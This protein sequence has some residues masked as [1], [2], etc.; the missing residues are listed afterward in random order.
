MEN[1]AMQDRVFISYIA[2]QKQYVD[3]IR[4]RLYLLLDDPT[5]IDKNFC[6]YIQKMLS[7]T[8]EAFRKKEASVAAQYFK[9]LMQIENALAECL[10]ASEDGLDR[11]QICLGQ[12]DFFIDLSEK[13]AALSALTIEIKD[14]QATFEKIEDESE[15]SIKIS[16]LRCLAA[17]DSEVQQQ[18]LDP[19]F[20]KKVQQCIA[21]ERPGL[22]SLIIE[23][24]R[25]SND[26]I[27]SV[28]LDRWIVDVA[29]EFDQSGK[30]LYGDFEGVTADA[31]AVMI[32]R[33]KIKDL[34]KRL[35]SMHTLSCET[36]FTNVKK[37]ID[38]SSEMVQLSRQ[39]VD[40]EITIL[41][42]RGME[43][44]ESSK[45]KKHI[46]DFF[47]CPDG[48][49]IH[50]VEAKS[51]IENLE[52]EASLS[53]STAFAQWMLHR[54]KNFVE[55]ALK[56]LSLSSEDRANLQAATVHQV[57][58]EKVQG[59]FGHVSRASK[60]QKRMPLFQEDTSGVYTEV[61]KREVLPPLPVCKYDKSSVELYF[62]AASKKP[63][64]PD[65][66]NPKDKTPKELLQWMYESCAASSLLAA[67]YK[68]IFRALKVLPVNYTELDAKQ[69]Q[70][71][72]LREAYVVAAA[73]S[74]TDLRQIGAF[75]A[76]V[77]AFGRIL[78]AIEFSPLMKTTY[79]L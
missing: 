61:T 11:I 39:Y 59:D 65:I 57:W 70:L 32:E 35:G 55:Q 24:L 33:E 31:L 74:H 14:T 15:E 37:V 51:I 16:T 25:T 36:L 53:M 26:P 58:L 69:L 64:P 45:L 66:S 73:R 41:Q 46:D 43:L 44:E 1:D 8:V 38:L 2:E 28:W 77:E 6:Q 78:H 72:K 63:A 12:I 5:N 13:I 19:L 48:T 68:T 75:H 34:F 18:N 3:A 27:L 60:N 54:A 42:K 67:N 17:L 56:G 71:R 30:P 21:A 47:Y 62:S 7:V 10:E 79:L 52:T 29:E 4:M 22:L 23:K 76:H 40:K 50:I 20:L 9:Q 49:A